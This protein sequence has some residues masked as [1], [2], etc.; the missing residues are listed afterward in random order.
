MLST[1]H[2]G[3]TLIEV[4]VAMV[5]LAF[6]LL[7]L[8][9]LIAKSHTSEF[10]A[11]QRAQGA[12]LLSDMVERINAN[13][14]NAAAYVT[15]APLGTGENQWASCLALPV[16]ATRDQCEWSKALQGSGETRAGANTGAMVGARGCIEPVQASNANPGFCAAGIYRVSIVWQGQTVTTAPGLACGQNLYTDDRMRR[17]L[18]A[19]VEI[20]VPDCT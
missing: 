3:F 18:A 16:G 12:V 10:D 19:L 20:G 13:R 11:Y 15:A 6:G 8:A 9:G 2:R 5:I 17:A 1:R 7:A 4:L 14:A